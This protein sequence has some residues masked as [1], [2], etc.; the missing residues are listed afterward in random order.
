MELQANLNKPEKMNEFFDFRVNT[1]DN[2]MRENI[3]AFDE[4]YS[5]ISEPIK[6]T[7]DKIKILDLGCGTG[8]ELVEI[9]NKVPNVSITGI[10]LSEKM[11]N[12]LQKKFSTKTDQIELKTGS[13]TELFLGEDEYDYVVSV[14]TMHHLLHKEKVSLYKKI[15]KALKKDGK[16]I[17][18]DYI[19]TMEKERIFL[20]KYYK[21]VKDYGLAKKDFFHIDIPFSI[22]T[23]EKLFYE[24]GFTQFNVIFNK[25]EA[26]IY[27]CT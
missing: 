12:L 16:Y 1:Y 2:H 3:K 13:Y 21:L 17:E 15:K 20:E 26:A 4:L 10:D 5:H 23:Q 22:K 27:V 14:M 6:A 11:L 8:L 18:G 24:A 7:N 9:L 25:E 19:V